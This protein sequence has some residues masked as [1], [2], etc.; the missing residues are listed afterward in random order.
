[1]HIGRQRGNVVAV[2]SHLLK[3]DN[4]KAAGGISAS[5]AI[6]VAAVPGLP[7]AQFDSGADL[8]DTALAPTLR[9]SPAAL[10]DGRR[11]AGEGDSDRCRREGLRA[12]H[13]TWNWAVVAG[14]PARVTTV[15]PLVP[16]A[17]LMHPWL[18][19]CH[20]PG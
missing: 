14:L 9:P 4:C 1:M 15:T 13:F 10:E 11:A 12:H 6:A 2:A 20:P 3:P 18:P 16:L 5:A 8:L 7:S 19:V 17:I